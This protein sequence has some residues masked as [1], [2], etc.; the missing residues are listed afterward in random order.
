MF[1]KV[2]GDDPMKNVTVLSTFWGQIPRERAIAREHE[3]MTT[4]DFWGSMI[5]HGAQVRRFDGTQKSAFDTLMSLATK[6]MVTLNIP[7]NLVNELKPLGETA[8]GKAVNEE[9]HRL[10]SKYREE[11]IQIQQETAAALAER[12]AKHGEILRVERQI[13]E[14]KLSHIHSRQYMLRQEHWEEIRRIE[15]H[16]KR[17]IDLLRKDYTNKLHQQRLEAERLHDEYKADM[18]KKMYE[19]RMQS[20]SL[21]AQFREQIQEIQDRND[22]RM[23]EMED[24]NEALRME[25]RN[26]ATQGNFRG[27]LA[28]LV[29][30]GAPVARGQLLTLP[31]WPDKGGN[32]APATTQGPRTQTLGLPETTKKKVQ[33]PPASTDL[34]NDQN[35]GPDASME[36]I[37]EELLLDMK[38]EDVHQFGKCWTCSPTDSSTHKVPITVSDVPVVIPVESRYPLRAPV[39]PPPDPHPRF[40][41]PTVHISDNVIS[42]IFEVYEKALGFYLLINGQLQMI[43][44]DDFDCE[45]ALSHRPREFGG[46]E[47]SYILESMTPTAGMFSQA[48]ERESQVS[49]VEVP[50]SAPGPILEAAQSAPIDPMLRMGIGAA[51]QASVKGGRQKDRFEG[52]VGVMTR[53]GDR[54]FVTIP[55]HIVTS[56]LTAAKSSSFPGESW[57]RDVQI[58][59]SNGNRELGPISET[60]DPKAGHF[61]IGFIHDVSLVDVSKASAALVENIKTP[62]PTEWLSNLGWQEIKYRTTKLYL[63]KHVSE[64]SRRQ[65]SIKSIGLLECQCQVYLSRVPWS[66]P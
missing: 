37:G 7:Y 13:V 34:D 26:S 51:I 48:S 8:W 17:I 43:I 18:R 12:D 30:S 15:A 54:T 44:P 29:G 2:C 24:E 57:T 52:R 33:V 46:L 3:L 50:E 9:L 42:E 23:R 56:A 4:P 6:A 28:T 58:F 22:K 59:S 40:I 45:Y 32:K 53:M 10:A 27:K 11:L 41:D 1:R 14:Q 39:S 20:T 21:S 64:E 38:L 55:T 16:N 66:C 31:S 35:L 25:A 65:A 5:K 36:S 19:V 47:V 63:L 62:I 49:T 61:P 60:F